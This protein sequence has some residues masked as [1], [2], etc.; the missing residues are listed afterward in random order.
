MLAISSDNVYRRKKFG[1]N[2]CWDSC[3]YHHTQL[4]PHTRLRR[5]CIDIERTLCVLYIYAHYTYINNEYA[6]RVR[7]AYPAASGWRHAR[8]ASGVK[9][10]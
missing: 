5:D 1:V 4:I 10:P 6:L 7:G 8:D 3:L 2:S 9:L